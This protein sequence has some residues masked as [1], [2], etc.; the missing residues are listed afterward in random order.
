VST[1]IEKA[2]FLVLT[3]NK[4]LQQHFKNYEAKLDE[5]EA[6]TVMRQRPVIMRP[7][8]VFWASR[9]RP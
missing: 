4:A 7:R 2:I 3:Y 6:T 5:A 9:P 1:Q 8:P